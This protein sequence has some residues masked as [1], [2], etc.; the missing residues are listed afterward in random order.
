MENIT[1]GNQQGSVDY[2]L[3]YIV[4]MIDGEGTVSLARSGK[5][6]TSPLFCK[7]QPLISI[8]GTDWPIM[9]TLISYCVDLELPYHVYVNNRGAK[10]II[11]LQ[12]YGLKRVSK[13]IEMLKVDF[14]KKEKLDLLNEYIKERTSKIEKH[15][16]SK[17]YSSREIEI[18]NAIRML[19]E[20]GGKSRHIFSSVDSNNS[21]EKERVWKRE[22]MQELID[23]KWTQE[24]IAKFFNIDQSSVNKWIKRN[25][26]TLNDYH[27]DTTK[28]KV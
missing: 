9:D 8:S 16:F 10:P 18:Y 15:P 7:L 12:A 6:K 19:N 2:K 24:K 27:Q 22:K 20:R 26:Q 28:V 25:Q 3:G 14:G 13:W 4:G 17:P 1:M 23:K 5:T 11:R 21:Q